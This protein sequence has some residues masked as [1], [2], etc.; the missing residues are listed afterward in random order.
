[1]MTGKRISAM[2]G[3]VLAA[4]ALA[5]TQ[6][7][8]TRGGVRVVHN[9][10]GGVWL[11]TPRIKLSPLFTLGDIETK[12]DNFVFAQPT[13]VAA[14]AA[15]VI[16]V[17]D[18]RDGL[19]KAYDKDGKFKASF[20]RRGQGP[21]EFGMP[22]SLSLG[23]GGNLLVGDMMKRKALWF[24]PE[25]Q[26]LEALDYSGSILPLDNGAY[27]AMFPPI[28]MKITVGAGGGATQENAFPKKLLRILDASLRPVSEFLDPI[29]REDD[30]TSSSYNQIRFA[31][32]G[33]SRVVAAFVSQNRIE[34]FDLEGRLL[35]R[36]DRELSVKLGPGK[37]PGMAGRAGMTTVSFPSFV[38]C[39]TGA[40]LDSRGRTWVLAYSRPIRDE[41][42][43]ATISSI[44][45]TR[46]EGNFDLRETDLYK[47]E[48]YDP[49]GVLL[50]ELPMTTFIDKISI[51]GD[52][53]FLLD[54]SRGAC[55][56]VLK[57]EDLS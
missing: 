52:R 46:R 22:A 36:A 44:D 3:A 50:E 48:V 56:H 47:L 25:G 32:D 43:I 37:A 12:D 19:I 21:G 23:H 53:L 1:M 38:S 42:R 54:S 57:I 35:W 13:A 45:G 4:T 55:V 15:G 20:G 30:P 29:F 34:S 2:I 28:A 7:V 17:L 9:K 14:D 27:L 6:T 51:A 8:E 24:T 40:A 5:A 26:F 41:E 10:K 33:K 11:K 18:S 16:Y 31:T 49:D 39:C